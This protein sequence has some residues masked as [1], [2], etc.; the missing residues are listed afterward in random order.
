MNPLAGRAPTLRDAVLARRELSLPD[1]GPDLL[2]RR[3]PRDLRQRLRQL[4]LRRVARPAAPPLRV[5]LPQ[6]LWR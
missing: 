6:Y 4:V 5:A 1:A 2:R 3:C